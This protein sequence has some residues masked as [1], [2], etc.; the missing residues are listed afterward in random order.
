MA[1][2]TTI[3]EWEGWK[4][5][6]GLPRLADSG[7]AEVEIYAEN[8]CMLSLEYAGGK[9]RKTYGLGR[10]FGVRVLSEG[11][12][13]F[14][15][16]DSEEGVKSALAQAM[17][18]SRYAEPCKMSFPQ[19]SKFRDAGA[20][21][22]K[23]HECTAPE[24]EYMLMELVEGVKE[25]GSEPVRAFAQADSGER[26]MANSSGLFARERS[27]GASFYVEA[28]NRDGQGSADHAG[29]SFPESCAEI[30]KKAGMMAKEMAGAKAPQAGIYEV[31]FSIEALHS[32][33]E[34]LADSLSGDLCFRKAS[35]LHDKLGVRLFSEN[36]SL[37]DDPFSPGVFARGFDGEGMPSRETKLI[38]GGKVSSF[39]YDLEWSS[40]SGAG[41]GG[42]C[43]R[44]GYKSP[45][46]IGESNL[47]IAA[48]DG[49]PPGINEYLFVESMH[50]MHTA[51]ALT[52]DFGAEASIAFH[53]KNGARVPVRGFMITD[54]IFN[55]FGRISSVGN[56]RSVSANLLAP[57]IRFSGVR[58]VS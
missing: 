42:N 50:G 49:D 44:T 55:L 46:G 1:Q 29:V 34:V 28:K 12:L 35:F 7:K 22:K 47:T 58:V 27:T 16:A 38:S 40:R 48:G 15:H 6:D 43:L 39:L 37:S 8:G 3:S 2:K 13:G 36:F 41:T 52:G 51:N 10:G 19:N 45:P 4:G 30:G 21:S 53:V 57:E 54:N 26:G 56:A 11:R 9:I 20:F 23:V 14:S 33:L 25:T 5:M 18:S 31:I 32:L 24:L 17:D